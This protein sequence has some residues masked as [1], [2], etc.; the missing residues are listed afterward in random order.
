MGLDINTKE[1]EKKC[2][3]YQQSPRRERC[4]NPRSRRLSESGDPGYG[5]E[6]I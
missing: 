5:T 3:P 1:S 6:Y 2:I 4:K